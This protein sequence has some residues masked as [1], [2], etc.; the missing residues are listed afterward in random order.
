M[1]HATKNDTVKNKEQLQEK[2]K[3]TKVGR[4]LARRDMKKA[5]KA[6]K[7][8]ED[9]AQKLSAQEVSR[10]EEPSKEAY[11]RC[12]TLSLTLKVGECEARQ[13]RSKSLAS[14]LSSSLKTCKR[15][16]KEGKFREMQKGA[17]LKLGDL[18]DNVLPEEPVPPPPV[19]GRFSKIFRNSD[20]N[21]G[22][23][24]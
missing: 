15:C 11:F 18:L 19:K 2:T 17:S 1:K 10:A 12:A 21:P 24:T 16:V 13:D 14:M 6:M 8:I 20:A 5:L 3:T 9:S 7:V 4:Y 22:N 23:E